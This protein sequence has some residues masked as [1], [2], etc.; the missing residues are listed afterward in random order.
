MTNLATR[1]SA[2]AALS[3]S[4]REITSVLFTDPLVVH[5]YGL[6]EVPCEARSV[7]PCRM[8]TV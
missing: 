4:G 8:S 5:E 2:F 6:D 3:T 1:A 7:D